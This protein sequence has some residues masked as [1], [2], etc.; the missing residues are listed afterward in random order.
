MDYVLVRVQ[1]RLGTTSGDPVL[2][3]SG[4]FSL[5]G[6][7]GDVYERP[8]VTTPFPRIDAVLYPGGVKQGWVLLQ[9]AADDRKLVLAVDSPFERGE[10]HRIYLELP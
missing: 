2:V 3:A 5:L 7:G 1:T 6:A 4:L 10:D 9:A 8:G